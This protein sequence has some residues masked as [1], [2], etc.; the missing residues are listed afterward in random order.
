[1]EIRVLF[2]NRKEDMRYV[3]G[4][5]VSFLVNKSILFDAGE[6]EDMLLHNMRL[7]D[8]RPDQIEKIVISHEHWDHV[9]GLWRL[10]MGSPGVPVYICPGFSREF[11]ERITSFGAKAIEVEPF[12]EIDR[13]I[14]TSGELAG[15]CRYGRIPEQ[16]L[17]LRSK[18]GITVIT[19]CAH[20]GIA[21]IL[22]SVQ[23]RMPGP[24]HLVLGGFHTLDVPLSVVGS[25]IKRFQQLGVVKVAPTHCTG[26]KAIRMFKEAYGSDFVEA[27]VGKTIYA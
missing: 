13:N 8:V 6:N 16:A 1:M 27:S 23:E 4:W 22:A 24:I 21:D 2:D 26:D 19:G 10:I 7:M 5:G 25:V 12:M 18:K 15:T 3:A 11:K 20:N 17:V 14:H 9:G